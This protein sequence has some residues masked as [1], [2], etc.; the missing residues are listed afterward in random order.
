MHR[1]KTLSL[2]TLFLLALITLF[3]SVGGFISD[4]IHEIDRTQALRSQMQAQIHES[5]HAWYDVQIRETQLI[6]RCGITAYTVT[7]LDFDGNE[8]T[9]YY[10]IDTAAPVRQDLISG[11]S[12]RVTKSAAVRNIGVAGA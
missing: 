8:F 9:L 2:A 7:L 10:D 3:V 4:R 5:I 11:C 6:S 12:G 1:M